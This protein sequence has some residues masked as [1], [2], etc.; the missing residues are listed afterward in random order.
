MCQLLKMTEREVMAEC[1]RGSEARDAEKNRE[2]RR[3]RLIGG[4]G[5]QLKMNLSIAG[6]P[7]EG[8]TAT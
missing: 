3:G 8:V 7:M 5:L 2:M 6:K 4:G 1:V